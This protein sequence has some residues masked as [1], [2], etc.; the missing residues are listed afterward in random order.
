MPSAATL[1][2]RTPSS[3]RVRAYAY[4]WSA[5]S[6]V[7]VVACSTASPQAAAPEPPPLSLGDAGPESAEATDGSKPEVDG[8][9]AAPDG[10]VVHADRFVTEVVSF[11]PGDCAGF[12]A[13][14]MP[15]I[16]EGPPVGGGAQM[17]GLDVLSLG[18][19]GEIVVGF[20]P[21][22]IVDGPGA[23][24]IVFE[25]AFLAGN[26]PN[27]PAADLGEISVSDDGT[28]WKTFPCASDATRTAPPYG[29]CAGWHPVYSTPTNGISPFDAAKAGGEAYDLADLGLTKA[30]Y[31]RI[32]DMKTASC[33][34]QAPRPTTVGFDLDA[35]AV[36]NAEMP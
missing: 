2:T 6:A 17:G 9:F 5:A 21:N 13:S 11:T 36:V 34:A 27:H 25:N 10:S 26:D 1:S 35:I 22:A 18:Y 23:D 28:T 24:F 29:S 8:G 20:T 3:L 14:G 33:P 4:A 31:V 7:L 32:V 30:R 19:G 16:V 15:K 12:G